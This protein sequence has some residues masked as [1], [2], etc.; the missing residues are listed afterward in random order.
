MDKKIKFKEVIKQIGGKN[1]NNCAW[2][3][4]ETFIGYIKINEELE[5]LFKELL[6]E[7]PEP[8][9]DT[10]NI[11]FEYWKDDNTF[12][13]MFMFE[14]DTVDI[15]DKIECKYLNNLVLNEANK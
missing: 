11:F 14:F 3:D 1:F 4:K 5:K 7:N 8:E 2:S 10:E 9:D 13:Y 12:H 6:E 15:G